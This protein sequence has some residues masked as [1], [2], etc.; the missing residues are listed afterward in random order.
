MLLAASA[1]FHV[2]IK[3]MNNYTKKLFLLTF[4]LC[5]S[6]EKANA[7]DIIFS[8]KNYSENLF[9]QSRLASK[10]KLN[11]LLN[12]NKEDLSS[13]PSETVSELSSKR[14]Y[15]FVRIK[16]IG[17]QAAWGTL[18]CQVVTRGSLNFDIP[19]LGPNTAQ[20][21]H[22]IIANNG[23]IFPSN[24]SGKVPAV[25]CTWKNLSTK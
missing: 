16:N 19:I 11:L 20:W 21:N 9:V 1:L 12:D 15:I 3:D 8:N 4:L 2:M 6:L 23:L 25:T 24:F 18:S 10:E 7:L 22:Y 14:T 17:K 5:F 13:I